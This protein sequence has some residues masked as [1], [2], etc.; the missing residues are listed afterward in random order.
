MNKERHGID[1]TKNYKDLYIKKK[2]SVTYKVPCE[3]FLFHLPN[4]FN[5][6]S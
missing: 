6:V 1:T 4:V 3:Y 2:K 5:R